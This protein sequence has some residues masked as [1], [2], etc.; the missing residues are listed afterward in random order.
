MNSSG[1]AICRVRGVERMHES[2]IIGEL[3]HT[4]RCGGKQCCEQADE[5][6]ENMLLKMQCQG[7][8]LF[9]FD[10]GSSKL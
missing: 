5:I 7:L 2:N 3:L 6:L 1:N 4:F 10:A 8:C 9:S